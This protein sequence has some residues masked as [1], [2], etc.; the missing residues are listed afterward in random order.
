MFMFVAIAMKSQIDFQGVYIGYKQ[1]KVEKKVSLNNAPYYLSSFVT[2]DG[3]AAGVT[4]IPVSYDKNS[5]LV[6]FVSETEFTTLVQSISNS[7]GVEMDWIKDDFLYFGS[8]NELFYSVAIVDIKEGFRKDD[9][10]YLIKLI[11]FNSALYDK[12]LEE[13]PTE[14]KNIRNN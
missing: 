14:N 13:N 11:I 9:V 7:F 5:D 1:E 4:C 12:W 2:K 3:F 8:K 6:R 10:L